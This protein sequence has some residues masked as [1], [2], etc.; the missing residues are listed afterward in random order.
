MDIVQ[1]QMLDSYRA[2]QHGEVPPPLP[3][4]HDRDVL[5]GIR[6]R[7]R[8]WASAHRPPLA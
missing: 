1:Q 2:A 8:A 4:R 3:G 5:R 6:R 7:I